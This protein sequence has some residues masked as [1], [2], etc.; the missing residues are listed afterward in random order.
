VLN[1]LCNSNLVYP[2]TSV[3]SVLYTQ[4]QLVFGYSGP[5]INRVIKG[6]NGIQRPP[7]I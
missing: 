4:I 3:L 6:Y 5:V 1:L 7:K 2:T